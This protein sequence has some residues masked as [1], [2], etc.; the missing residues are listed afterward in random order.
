MAI[1]YN[2]IISA[3]DVV[4]KEGEL[5]N[6][7][8]VVHWRRS[9]TEVVD[10][11]TYTAEVYSTYNCPSPSSTDFTAYP[12]LTQAQVESWLNAGLDVASI[13][14]NIATQIEQQI[15]PP[16]VTPQLPWNQTTNI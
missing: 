12:D 11:K 9:G 1:T 2:W 8:S 3:M 15:N 6:V 5:V 10:G 4:P 13:D 7:V 14:Q 16:V